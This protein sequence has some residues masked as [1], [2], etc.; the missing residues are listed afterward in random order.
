MIPGVQHLGFIVPFYITQMYGQR[1]RMPSRGLCAEC[2]EHR[3]RTYITGDDR[4]YCSDC[5]M[6]DLAEASP[7]DEMKREQR[8]PPPYPI[9]TRYDKMMNV[10]T[11]G[12][13]LR[14][15]GAVQ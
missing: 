14:V 6:F 1:W 5:I 7:S 8:H 15:Y 10:I 4:P 11:D 3:P 2:G 12:A 9:E 13:N